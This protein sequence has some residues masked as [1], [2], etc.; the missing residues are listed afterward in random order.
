MLLFCEPVPERK[1]GS[2]FGSGPSFYYNHFGKKG[3]RAAV[4]HSVFLL[5]LLTQSELRLTMIP[6]FDLEHITI[7]GL[8]FKVQH[9]SR[10]NNG[11]AKDVH[12]LILRICEQVRLHDVLTALCFPRT[13]M[14][15]PNPQCVCIWR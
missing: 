1:V 8:Q 4:L 12:V 7:R 5:L 13:H 6:S 10:Q 2:L 14:L 15:K 3:K 11:L 9:H